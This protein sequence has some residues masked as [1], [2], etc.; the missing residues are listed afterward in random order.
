MFCS[1]CGHEVE[2]SYGFCPNCGKKLASNG[3]LVDNAINIVNNIFNGAPTH[4]PNKALEKLALE[5]VKA[6]EDESIDMYETTQKKI[7]F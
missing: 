1:A 4:E 7:S 5:F 6:D 3:N 2:E